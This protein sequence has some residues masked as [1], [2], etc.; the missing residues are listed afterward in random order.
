VSLFFQGIYFPYIAYRYIPSMFTI[1]SMVTVN[2]VT[3]NTVSLM[4]TCSR[5]WTSVLVIAVK[6]KDKA[7]YLMKFGKT[8]VVR[9]DLVIAE[10]VTPKQS[11]LSVLL[12]EEFRRFLLSCTANHFQIA[13]QSALM[14][15]HKSCHIVNRGK[16][17]KL[18]TVCTSK[19]LAIAGLLRNI[20]AKYCSSL[21]D[22]G[23][24]TP[25]GG[26]INGPK[27]A[28]QRSSFRGISNCYIRE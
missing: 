28:Y 25:T 21:S 2:I 26:N 5:M 19:A 9:K 16:Y 20:S 1:P 24:L 8:L 13:V 11:T 15:L 14:V 6:F 27:D 3:V 22:I 18:C 23:T 12:S 4:T 10:K 17:L 7:N